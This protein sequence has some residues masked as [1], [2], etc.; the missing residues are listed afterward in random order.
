M[1]RKDDYT[2]ERM[3]DRAQMQDVMLRWCRA[4][5]RR[6]ADSVRDLFHPDAT[7][8]HG[9]FQGGVDALIAWLKER[10]KTIPSSNHTVGNMLIEFTGKDS[11]IMESYCI[12]IQ[13]YPADAQASLTQLS[14]GVTAAAAQSVDLFVIARYLDM[15]ERRADGEWRIARRTVLFDST[16]MYDVSANA[17]KLDPKW[18]LGRRDQDDH[19]FKERRAAGLK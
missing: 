9:V 11:A 12:C 18:A 19:V 4:V 15:F 6:D 1:S 10:H 16:M 14:G 3:A 5:D 8:D 17:P 13:R 2:P 7:D